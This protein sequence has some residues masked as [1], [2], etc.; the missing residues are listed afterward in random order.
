MH[1]GRLSSGLAAARQEFVRTPGWGKTSWPCRAQAERIDRDASADLARANGSTGGELSGWP[2]DYFSA[3]NCATTYSNGGLTRS[4][5]VTPCFREGS[6]A[7]HLSPSSPGW[8]RH[9][10]HRQGLR[11]ALCP[12]LDTRMLETRV[13]SSKRASRKVYCHQS[14]HAAL[15]ACGGRRRLANARWGPVPHLAG[16]EGGPPRRRLSARRGFGG[17]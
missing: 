2:P 17:R 12:D 6:I 7:R 1:L 16:P 15:A 9:I 11:T 8:C 4:K 5:S 13:Y 10:G 3:A 14:C